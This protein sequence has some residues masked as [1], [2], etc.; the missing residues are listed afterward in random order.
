MKFN[1]WCIDIFRGFEIII[2]SPSKLKFIQNFI[3]NEPLKNIKEI[4]FKN[5]T[6]SHFPFH[7]FPNIKFLELSNTSK[8]CL[9]DCFYECQKL[10]ILL[11]KDIDLEKIPKNIEKCSSLIMISIISS[12]LEALPETIGNLSSLKELHITECFQLS[13][14]PL[15]LKNCKYL[16][17]IS[18]SNCSIT[19]IPDFFL[20][21]N[22]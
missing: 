13:Y 11:M 6:I 2:D 10:E 18:I 20:N 9:V 15:S 14:L 4:K 16:E 1:Q 3:D 8:N 17:S 22:I 12:S 21:L 7:K 19:E 5:I